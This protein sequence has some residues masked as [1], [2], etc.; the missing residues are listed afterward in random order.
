[1]SSEAIA[2]RYGRALFELAK[3]K[4]SVAEVT[5]ELADFA[6]AFEASDELR[7][8]QHAPNLSDTEREA[9]IEELG[10]RIGASETTTRS[11]AMLATRRRLAILPD[12]VRIVGEMADDH[13]GVLHASV[14][15]AKTLEQDHLERLQREIASATGKTVILDF[16]VD[17]SLIAGIVTRIGDRVIDG[18]IRGRINRLAESLRTP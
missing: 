7:A 16:E 13:L 11:V 4:S 10:R 6:A 1:M 12:L 5:R 18:S 3:E 8:L 14:R 2:R 9:V 15:A 17:P